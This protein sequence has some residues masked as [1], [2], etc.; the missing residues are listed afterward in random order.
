MVH[1]RT[2]LVLFTV[3]VHV[4]LMTFLP[5]DFLMNT[6]GCY[7]CDPNPCEH[8]GICSQD[9]NTFSCNCDQTGYLGGV[10]HKCKADTYLAK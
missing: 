2:V 9:F 8:G 6:S 1:L 4:Y 3:V 10:C 7:R 5:G